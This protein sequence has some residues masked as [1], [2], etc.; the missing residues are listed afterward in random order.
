MH[1]APYAR[2]DGRMAAIIDAGCSGSVRSVE[3]NC[4]IKV[5]FFSDQ[6]QLSEDGWLL[7]VI[8]ETVEHAGACRLCKACGRTKHPL[9]PLPVAAT[10]SHW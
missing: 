2:E 9:L 1:E 5:D 6:T 8:K 4:R 10:V 3:E 7:L